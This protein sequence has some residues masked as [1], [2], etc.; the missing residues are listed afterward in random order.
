MVLDQ[1]DA[2]RDSKLFQTLEHVKNTDGTFEAA[3]LEG[4]KEL[5]HQ[6]YAPTGHL[7]KKRSRERVHSAWRKHKERPGWWFRRFDRYAAT[8]Q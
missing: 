1:G 2:T 3:G 7:I 8:T 6:D 4:I 5:M